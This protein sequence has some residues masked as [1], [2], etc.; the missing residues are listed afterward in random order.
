[1]VTLSPNIFKFSLISTPNW[2]FLCHWKRKQGATNVFWTSKKEEQ[3]RKRRKRKSDILFQIL[4]LDPLISNYILFI[5]HSFWKISKVTNHYFKIY[6]TCL[7]WKV[8]ITIVEELKVQNHTKHLWKNPKHNPLHFEKAYLVHF[9]WD[10][11]IIYK[12]GYA[13]ERTTKLFRVLKGTDHGQESYND[14]ILLNVQW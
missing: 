6:K 7:K 13:R 11:S 3:S 8:K 1:M 4:F 2:T 5:S 9:P 10:C 14:R 12:F